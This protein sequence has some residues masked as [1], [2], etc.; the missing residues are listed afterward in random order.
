MKY[1]LQYRG[2]RVQFRHEAKSGVS[3]GGFTSSAASREL[4][5]GSELELGKL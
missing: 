1:V 4:N 2:S 3:V 5:F